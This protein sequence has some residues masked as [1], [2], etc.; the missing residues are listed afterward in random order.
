MKYSIILLAVI[1]VSACTSPQKREETSATIVKNKLPDSLLIMPGQSIGNIK[2]GADAQ[3]FLKR[4]GKPDAQD[5]AMGAA[6]YTWFARHDTSGYRISVYGHRN[7]GAADEQ[8]VLIKKIM[9]TSPGY[10][11]AEGVRTGI[12]KDSISRFYRLTEASKY[13]VKAKTIQTFADISKGI[14]FDIDAVTK[15][16]TAISIFKPGDT[17]AVNIDLY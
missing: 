6:S 5:A 14:S 3:A 7:F 8:I 13:S 12:E 2:I 11:T 10:V 9:I 1:G 15:K 16:C 4:Y 17:S